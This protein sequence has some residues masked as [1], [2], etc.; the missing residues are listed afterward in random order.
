M[1]GD[2][3]RGER[4]SA[5]RLRSCNNDIARDQAQTKELPVDRGGFKTGAKS[6]WRQFHPGNPLYQGSLMSI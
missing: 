5:E 3:A 2:K 1:D 4:A 6:P